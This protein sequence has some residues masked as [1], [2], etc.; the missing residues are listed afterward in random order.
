MKFQRAK[1]H[2]DELRAL[3]HLFFIT[4]P[5]SFSGKPDLQKGK[6]EY[7][8]DIVKAVPPEIPLI[9]GDVIQTL[10][11]AL[12][13]LAYQLYRR[14]PGGKGHGKH[15]YFPIAEDKE[16]YEKQKDG[17]TSGMS[18]QAI[19][20]IDAIQP[21]KGGNDILWH[22]HALNIIDKH[23]TILTG[24]STVKAVDILKY[25]S[26]DINASRRRSP[27]K[28]PFLPD[29]KFSGFF[30][31]EPD[32]TPLQVGTLVFMDLT[33]TEVRKV[34]VQFEIALYEIGIVNAKPLLESLQG[35]IDAVEKALADL[36]PFTV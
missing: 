27:S 10:R 4:N 14:G 13:H 3:A 28:S 8:M 26:D 2:M 12:D 29:V 1:R 5:Y 19:N 35:M 23:R 6:V 15:I 18:S 34:D 20:A 7:T 31:G 33:K 11:S 30:Q 16:K 9:A 17:Q 22:L 21:Y 25:I 24:G 36:K 32:P